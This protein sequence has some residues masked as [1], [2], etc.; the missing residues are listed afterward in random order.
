ME[1]RI[2]FFDIDGTLLDEQTHTVPLSTKE[3]IKKAQINGHICIVNTGRTI[4]EINQTIKD[5]NFDGYIC[6]CGTYIEYHQQEIF[7]HQ[8]SN[9]LKHKV[10]EL[11]ENCHMQTILEGKNIL[12]FPQY[13]YHPFL[14]NI[15]ED[16]QKEGFHMTTYQHNSLVEFDKFTSWYQGNA[17]VEIFKDELICDFDIIQRDID[18]IEVVPK[19]YSKAT[20]IQYLIDYLGLSHE[21]TISIG[22]SMNDLSMLTYTHESVAMGN[23]HPALFEI[24]TFC[25]KDIQNN[26]I[27][28]A[29]KNFHLI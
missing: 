20:G 19:G 11:S 25:T 3:A 9:E 18:F 29:L 27:E 23:S 13:I 22:D 5:L 12:A 16:Y 21:Q 24:V 2:I 26:G 7:H 1:K 17:N 4:T 14:K 28:Y 8:L 6:G 15:K 10:I